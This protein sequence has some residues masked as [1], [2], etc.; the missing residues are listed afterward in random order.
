MQSNMLK[1]ILMN[2]ML[3]QHKDGT[4]KMLGVYG[5][6]T[7]MLTL[8]VTQKLL[9]DNFDKKKVADLMY[10]SGESQAYNAASWTV[11]KVGIPV[12]GN[13]LKIFKEI[14]GH[15]EITGMGKTKIIRFDIKNKVIVVKIMNN[16]F[17]K[18]YMKL[19][20]KQKEGVDHYLRGQVGGLIKF[21]FGE[22]TIVIDKGDYSTGKDAGYYM[23]IPL[24][25][26]VKKYGEFVKRFIP[27]KTLKT[28][29][30]KKIS[31]KNLLT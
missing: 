14:A 21:L 13:E 20:G 18:Q 5:R 28:E 30:L 8:A 27:D 12:K 1:R 17:S 9:E 10:L 23:A 7:T 6:L 4:L 25:D 16:V 19:F 3:F 31:I 11:K 29:A 26:S 22:E 15:T 2:R 24:K